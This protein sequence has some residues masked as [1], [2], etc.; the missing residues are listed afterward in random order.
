MNQIKASGGSRISM[1][2]RN[3]RIPRSIA[4]RIDFVLH[5]PKRLHTRVTDGDAPAQLAR[6]MGHMIS[7]GPRTDDLYAKH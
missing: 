3:R 1:M 5:P 4:P 6:S 2:K 7:Q